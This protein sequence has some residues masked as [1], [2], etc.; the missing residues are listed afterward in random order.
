MP[1]QLIESTTRK[2]LSGNQQSSN[3]NSWEKKANKL[4]QENHAITKMT[5][6][7]AQY[8]SALKIYVSA[9]SADGVP[10]TAI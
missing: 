6:R 9:K 3:E 2:Q 7:C 10:L 5:A 4:Q 8:M 1:S